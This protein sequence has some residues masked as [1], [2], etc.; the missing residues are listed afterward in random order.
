MSST[1]STTPKSSSSNK[2]LDIRNKEPAIQ[3]QVTSWLANL[4]INDNMSTTGSVKAT[5]SS[6]GPKWGVPK[7]FNGQKN[8]F[9][10]FK[11]Q[12]QV[13]LQLNADKIDT[14]HKKLMFIMTYLTGAAYD[15]IQPHLEDYMDHLMV[16]KER[17]ETTRVIFRT[18]ETMFAEMNAV[19]GNGNKQQEAKRELQAIKQRGSAAKYKA[20]F[21]ILAAK[22]GWN[23][24]ALVAQF[25]QGLK[26]TVKDEIACLDRP[27]N[28][29]ELYDLALKIDARQ[30]K[31]Q[32]ER[33]GR[34]TTTW[35]ANTK[36]KQDP[37][38][39]RNDYY[40]LQKMEINA[41]QGKPGPPRKG[42]FKRKTPP[43]PR[44]T[45]VDKECYGCGKKG[46]FI[47]DCQSKKQNV[48][49]P[50][51]MAATTSN[52]DS[53]SWTACY[54][55]S[56]TTHLSDKDGSGW[57]PKLPKAQTMA[58]TRTVRMRNLEQEP[59]GRIPT[60]D[61][62]EWRIVKDLTD[63]SED[64]SGNKSSGDS[65]KENQPPSRD[66]CRVRA[67]RNKSV[68]W[69]LPPDNAAFKVLRL[70]KEH[71]TRMF[72]RSGTQQ[73]VNQAEFN[74]FLT[75]LWRLA[76][77]LPLQ[78][79]T[80]DYTS[81]VKEYP[82]FG[83]MFTPRGGYFTPDGICISQSLRD[84]VRVL[85]SKYQLEWENQVHRERITPVYKEPKPRP[86]ICSRRPQLKREDATISEPSGKD[87]VF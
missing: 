17:K 50:G 56:C 26:D 73:Y 68:Q 45:K 1:G 23:N 19:F 37:P 87:R 61:L 77:S 81:F 65:D 63:S 34:P 36:V 28:P 39:W 32:M 40:G 46:H 20:E 60:P 86:A 66:N 41:T 85:Q 76:G 84:K 11:L 57:F 35:S 33:K 24:K 13:Y 42:G 47:R 55:D 31:R 69:V 53:L 22:T 2:P 7:E 14:G 4:D 16:V 72:P 21:Q 10:T 64:K 48:G 58:A 70:V 49:R 12:C 71:A 62:T 78:R 8:H 75:R 5:T 9:K 38:K 25:Y 51:T 6:T 18:P 67:A 3:E 29:R 27:R 54:D 83:S 43:N 59:N 82:P 80:L 30:Y 15:W 74:E 79:G 44:S 52:H